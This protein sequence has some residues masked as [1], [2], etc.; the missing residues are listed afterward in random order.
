MKFY[1]FFYFFLFLQYKGTLWNVLITATDFFFFFFLF[2]GIDR[3][4][5]E[6]AP[7]FTFA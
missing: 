7:P 1:F 2:F 5:T 4:N 3:T 6:K